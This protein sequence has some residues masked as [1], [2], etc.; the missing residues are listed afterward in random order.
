MTEK[1][2]GTSN[3]ME[4]LISIINTIMHD[5]IWQYMNGAGWRHD[6]WPITRWYHQM[7]SIQRKEHVI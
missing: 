2:L 5:N 7:T 6:G 3:R 4:G 1:M